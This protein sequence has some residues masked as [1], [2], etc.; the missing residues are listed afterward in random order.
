MIV[1]STKYACIIQLKLTIV[2]SLMEAMGFQSILRWPLYEYK[3]IR[4]PKIKLTTS[5]GTALFIGNIYPCWPVQSQ[6]G[7]NGASAG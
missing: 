5:V 3:C 6:A 2:V 4:V 7:L 1:F